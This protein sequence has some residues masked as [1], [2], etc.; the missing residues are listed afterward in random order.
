MS[1]IALMVIYANL[2]ILYLK[3]NFI[4]AALGYN[5]MKA[6]VSCRYKRLLF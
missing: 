5:V 6:V 4:T 2:E 1:D 3:I